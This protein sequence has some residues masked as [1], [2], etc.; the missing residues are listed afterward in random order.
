MTGE[1]IY[2]FLDNSGNLQN[3]AG[4]GMFRFYGYNLLSFRDEK[5]LRLYALEGDRTRLGVRPLF[6]AASRMNLWQDGT[7]VLRDVD[8]DGLAECEGDCDDQDP[9][10]YPGAPDLCDGK[11]NDCN[12]PTW[13]DGPP[14]GTALPTPGT[15]VDYASTSPPPPPGSPSRSR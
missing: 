8:G 11:G 7:P 1:E 5:L 6:A 4:K 10:T 9:D 2:L 12:D 3:C 14:T 15:S 13:P